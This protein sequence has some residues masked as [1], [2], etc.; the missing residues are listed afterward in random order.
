MKLQVRVF[1]FISLSF[2]FITM[3]NAGG[4]SSAKWFGQSK[5]E[6][7]TPEN[8]PDEKKSCFTNNFTIIAGDTIGLHYHKIFNPPHHIERIGIGDP[9]HFYLDVSGDGIDDVVFHCGNSYGAIGYA[10][11]Y[12]TVTAV[13]TNFVCFSRVDSSYC[14]NGYKPLYFTNLFLLNDTIGDQLQ[15]TQNE[16]IIDKEIWSMGDTCTLGIV[17]TGLKYLALGIKSGVV[18]G[19]AWVKLDLFA[20]GYNGFSADVVETGFKTLINSMPENTA[21]EVVVYPNPSDG[22]ITI[23]IPGLKGIWTAEIY[24]VVGREIITTTLTSK[25][26]RIS[27]DKGA[28]LLKLTRQDQHSLIKKIVVR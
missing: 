23:E 21:R 20:Q 3:V 19:L 7:P 11:N 22:D 9:V 13:D 16:N 28:Y 26:T 25:I 27:L 5:K 17:N 18:A 14:F 12:L 2:V 6:H 4:N 24:D 8:S 1:L 10:N 15:Y